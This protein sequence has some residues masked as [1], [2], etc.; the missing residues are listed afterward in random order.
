MG[1]AVVLLFGAVTLGFVVFL[2]IM[3]GYKR[4]IPVDPD[5]ILG[6][7]ISANGP[8]AGV[9]VIAET[10]DLPT[11]FAKIVVTDDDGHYLLPELPQ[12]NYDIWV[13]GYGMVDS[14]KQQAAPG[15]SLDLEAVVA[16]S[17]GAAA[18]YY[19]AIYWYSMLEIPG[20]DVFPGTG[21]GAN[22]NGIPQDIVSQGNWLRFVKLDGCLSCH[23]VGNK[24]TRSFPIDFP[25]HETSLAKWTRRIQSGQASQNMVRAAAWL[26]T[27]RI[28]P[29][30]ADWSDRIAAG[31]LPHA[32]PA[33]PTGVERNIVVTLWDWASPTM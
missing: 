31:E 1:K 12:A 26:G 2:A 24:A 32:Q 19:P 8:E 25:E 21:A 23:Q 14:Q 20:E 33:R 3:A 9:W 27:D 11:K 13:R 22:G 29:L 16:P 6:R 10:N 17:A 4:E 15:T 18:E 5:V 30:L 7:V 28:L